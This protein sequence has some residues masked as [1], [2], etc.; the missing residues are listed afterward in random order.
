M[1]AIVCFSGGHSSALAAIE[2]VKKYGRENTILLN[3][4]ISNKVEHTD[5][6]RFKREV[7]QYC[8]VPITYANMENFEEMTPL[9]IAVTSKGFQAVPE[10][11][12]CTSRLKTE[13]FY[14]FLE[15]FSRS[16]DIHICYGFDEEETNRINRRAII[17]RAMGFTPEFPLADWPR[18][19]ARTEDLGI[20]RPV[21][22]RMYKH[23]NCIGCLKAG[24]QH[25]YCVFCTR[26]DI[27]QEAKDAEKILGH[28]IIKGV[29]LEELEP[30]FHHMRDNLHICPND[31]ENSASFWAR[32]EKTLPE[33]M[34]L[35]PCDC[36]F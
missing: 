6:K 22:Y 27:W 1:K 35:L 34:T 23:A 30:K 8:G 20:P 31:R 5:I 19:I 15:Q 17:I 29:Y 9:K 7:A 12:F 28:S 14:H 36:A 10:K 13:P 11:A 2:A 18:T 26:D 21:T 33:Q 32:V 25:W 24:R 4:D 16:S 3:H